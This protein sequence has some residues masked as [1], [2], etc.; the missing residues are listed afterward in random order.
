MDDITVNDMVA[1][2]VEVL[3][4]ASLTI[5]G[6]RLARDAPLALKAL[7]MLGVLAVAVT[8]WALFVS[9]QSVFSVP[10]LEVLLRIV[11]L[12]AGVLAFGAITRPSWAIVVGVIAAV[13]TLLIYVG[14]FARL[15][16]GGRVGHSRGGH[17]RGPAARRPLPRHPGRAAPR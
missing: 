9:P 17:D 11:V 4:M 1:F 10:L 8:L 16:P 2:V 12:T 6:W 15:A 13:N 14:P 5:W 7:G 3:A